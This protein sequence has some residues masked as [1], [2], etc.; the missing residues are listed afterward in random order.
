[1]LDLLHISLLSLP[2]SFSLLVTKMKQTTM[3][4]KKDTLVLIDIKKMKE[5]ADRVIAKVNAVFR[6]PKI[7]LSKLHQNARIC[8]FR[9]LGHYI[10]ESR[11]DKFVDR[12]AY[13]Y[14]SSFPRRGEP[15]GI[16]NAQALIQPITQSILKAQHS[17]GKKDTGTETKLIHLNGLKVNPKIITLHPRKNIDIDKWAKD[18]E[19][20]LFG[21]VLSTI[22]GSCKY[23]PN[24]ST[25]DRR[26]R[27]RCI[28]VPKNCETFYLFEV[29]AI[30][31]REIDLTMLEIYYA[32]LSYEC[33][34]LVIHPAKTHT[35][36]LCPS[37]TDTDLN[38]N[39]IS[40]FNE[41][42]TVLLKTRIKGIAG[43]DAI[44]IKSIKAKEVIKFWNYDSDMDVT[45]LYVVPEMIIHFPLDEL[46]LRI[47]K[48]IVK[49]KKR[50]IESENDDM[51]E[52]LVVQ[53]RWD[54][55]DNVCHD[56][57]YRY[58]SLR[59]SSS[60]FTLERMLEL[61]DFNNTFRKDYILSNDPYEIEKHLGIIAA[62]TIHEMNYSISLKANKLNLSY[63]HVQILCAK[64]FSGT[65]LLPITPQGFSGIRGINP[66]DKLSYQNYGKH[67][68]R[69]PLRMIGKGKVP[70]Y[71]VEGLI[72]ST[73]TGSKFRYG[74]NYARFEINER[75][76]QA[77]VD[78]CS[79]A[80][81]IQ[82]YGLSNMGNR[83]EGIDF[84]GVGQVKHI[85]S[86]L[87]TTLKLRE[88]IDVAF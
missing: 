52:H 17:A 79:E 21:E 76:R 32:V 81:T 20:C 26:K 47:G 12:I 3:T 27:N 36:E 59:G 57:E 15:V 87:S 19:H 72:A 80:K 86:G 5:I 8:A 46:S 2:A 69:E 84:Y 29:D 82:Y 38:D 88:C 40:Q 1:M 18:N 50:C 83:Y 73:I 14:I 68:G 74:S 37:A 11:I 43:V 67:L 34:G 33:F 53:G 22:F 55:K 7:Y 42:I 64:M 28:N 9:I 65:A 58:L 13:A 4:T 70:K 66:L 10:Y 6:N 60:D 49:R 62:Q 54:L 78:A 35:F 44:D 51:P 16:I 41:N 23:V 39:V 30:K 63:P 31:L 77:I 56:T 85:K 45:R 61:K 48:D 75:A 24:T 25:T 71:P